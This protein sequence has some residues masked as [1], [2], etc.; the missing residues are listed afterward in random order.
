MTFV[1]LQYETLGS[2]WLPSAVCLEHAD[3]KGLLRVTGLTAAIIAI[4]NPTVTSAAEKNSSL[5]E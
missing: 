3:S 5:D 4:M 2:L 1:K